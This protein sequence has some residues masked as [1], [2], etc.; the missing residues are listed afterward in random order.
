MNMEP[1]EGGCL[2]GAIRYR[3]LEPPSRC[4]ICHCEQ[5]RKHSGGPCLSF[6]HFAPGSFEW[7]GEQ[8]T[9]YRSSQYAERGFCAKCGS[10]VSMHEEVLADR[11][12]IATGTLDE[13]HRVEPQDHVWVQSQLP[14]MQI[15]DDLPR[16]ARSSNAVPSKAQEPKK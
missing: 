2:C 6:V 15:R 12:Q 3:S 16:F 4:M 7:L 14:W 9:R 13:P 1:F 5:C 10:T 8:P 11:I